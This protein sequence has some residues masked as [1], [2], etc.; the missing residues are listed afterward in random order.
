MR[1]EYGRRAVRPRPLGWCPHSRLILPAGRAQLRRCT[2]VG[3]ANGN[4]QRVEDE[5][6]KS[7]GGDQRPLKM[8]KM[9]VDPEMYMKTKDRLTV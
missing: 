7:R 3:G 9:K 8:L 5:D 2:T 4:N 6:E 1:G